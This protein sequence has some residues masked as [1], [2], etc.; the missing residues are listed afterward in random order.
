MILNLPRM[1]EF[2]FAKKLNEL[3]NTDKSSGMKLF[4]EYI[5]CFLKKLYKRYKSELLSV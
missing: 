2:K 5:G 1:D 4:H 3:N